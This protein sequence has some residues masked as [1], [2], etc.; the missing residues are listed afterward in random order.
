MSSLCEAQQR[1]HTW[2]EKSRVCFDPSKEHI[3]VIHPDDGDDAE[4]IEA[5]V[6]VLIV[7]L[8]IIVGFAFYECI[9]KPKCAGKPIDCF[10]CESEYD[11]PGYRTKER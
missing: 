2:G 10:S 7:A 5:G 4:G 3:H 11:G 1:A 8:V 6:V 9:I